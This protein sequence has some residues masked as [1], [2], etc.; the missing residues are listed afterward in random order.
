VI[1]KAAREVDVHVK[2]KSSSTPKRIVIDLL[3]LE[4]IFAF[5]VC[6]HEYNMLFILV[7]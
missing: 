5:L 4:Y 2:P 3:I 7:P 1:V 6:F